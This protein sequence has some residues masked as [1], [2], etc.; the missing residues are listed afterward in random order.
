MVMVKRN[1][2]LAISTV[3]LLVFTTVYP[4]VILVHGTIAPHKHAVKSKVE[5][6]LPGGE[7]FE[8]LSQQAY[9]RGHVVVPFTWSGIPRVADMEQGGIILA[10]II[11]SY[12]VNEPVIVVAHSHGGNVFMKALQE[13]HHS[14][15]KQIPALSAI[16]VEKCIE[17]VLASYNV[18]RQHSVTSALSLLPAP[19][20]SGFDLLP[21]A[22]AGILL[23]AWK[24]NSTFTLQAK[25]RQFL[26]DEVYLLGTPINEKNF[27]PQ[28]ELVGQ[29]FNIYSEGDAVQPAGFILAYGTLS[30]RKFN[31][32][33][34][35][36]NI[37]L[38]VREKDKK[39]LAVVGH[40]ALH[41]PIVGEW[42][43]HCSEYVNAMK[44]GWH[45]A[46][47]DARLAL[48]WEKG[49]IYCG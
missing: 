3:V 39:K 11:A 31:Q 10:R 30:D 46:G 13:L 14:F 29:L 15:R 43:F 37:E 35:I 2:F 1:F 38:F 5:W 24:E 18:Q 20:P 7:F 27:Y 8:N 28:T 12:A 19:Q 16:T 17:Q 47:I 26:V 49:P 48:D 45:G 23:D 25:K 21:T 32:R 4:V 41:S 22:R 44:S 34:K 6:W 40:S 36:A 42:L 33:A 9:V